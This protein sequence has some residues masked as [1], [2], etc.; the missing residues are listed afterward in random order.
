MVIGVVITPTRVRNRTEFGRK[1]GAEGN[2]EAM[3]GGS[4]G[5]WEGVFD[6]FSEM[7]L[8]FGYEALPRLLS[9]RKLLN[10]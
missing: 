4:N 7:W 10:R 5:L 9:R 2:E 8:Y 3:S 6:K 1:K